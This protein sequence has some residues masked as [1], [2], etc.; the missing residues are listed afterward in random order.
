M[1][2][3]L[4]TPFDHIE[5]IVLQD[6]SSTMLDDGNYFKE[7]FTFP[8]DGNKKYN[9]GFAGFTMA[10]PSNLS[11]YS[12]VNSKFKKELNQDIGG[13]FI[14]S[15]TYTPFVDYSQVG[16]GGDPRIGVY[17][18]QFL[19]DY[20][21]GKYEDPY[22]QVDKFRHTLS[23]NLYELRNLKKD[24]E[25][26]KVAFRNAITYI[27]DEET[28][29]RKSYQ[30]YIYT[31]CEHLAE[32]FA[33]LSNIR[34]SHEI[35]GLK[36]PH[37]EWEG[38]LA[39]DIWY[40]LLYK[41]IDA[42]YPFD[43]RYM[44]LN[45]M[46]RR[47]YN[48]SGSVTMDDG[49]VL[50]LR[51]GGTC[52]WAGDTSD[53][54]GLE[55]MTD[56]ISPDYIYIWDSNLWTDYRK[57][58]K[59]IAGT[60]KECT[61]PRGVLEKVQRVVKGLEYKWKY[62]AGQLKIG[63]TNQYYNRDSDGDYEWFKQPGKVYANHSD[64]GADYP[65]YSQF[66]KYVNLHLGAAYDAMKGKEYCELVGK[67]GT[68]DASG[69]ITYV[70]PVFSDVVDKRE[71]LDDMVESGFKALV[72]AF[73]VVQNEHLF[74]VYNS[75]TKQVEEFDPAKAGQYSQSQCAIALERVFS[76]IYKYL[77][78]KSTTGET[79]QRHINID[80]G[81]KY[82]TTKSLLESD[83][84]LGI[85]FD[86]SDEKKYL[87]YLKKLNDC[88]AETNF[89][90]NPPVNPYGFTKDEYEV[91]GQ[92]CEILSKQALGW[93]DEKWDLCP[94]LQRSETRSPQFSPRKLMSRG[95]TAR[96]SD[97]S[98]SKRLYLD[99]TKKGYMDQGWV[100]QNEI[101]VPE[102]WHSTWPTPDRLCIELDET[103]DGIDLSK[104]VLRSNPTYTYSSELVSNCAVAGYTLSRNDSLIR[105]TADQVVNTVDFGDDDSLLVYAAW[106][107]EYILEFKSD[108]SHYKSEGWG[109]QWQDPEPKGS[110]APKKLPQSGGTAPQ[111][112]FYPPG[113]FT[114]DGTQY[115]ERK[116]KFK[117]YADEQDPPRWADP[118]EYNPDQQPVSLYGFKYWKCTIGGQNYS[119]R[120]GDPIRVNVFNLDSAP[121]VK[122]TA[123][124][125]RA[126]D[127]IKFNIY[128]TLYCEVCIDTTINKVVYP[129]H[130]P[131]ITNG[132]YRFYGWSSA[133]GDYLPGVDRSTTI[134]C[135]P[136]SPTDT[137]VCEGQPDY[138]VCKEDEKDYDDPIDAYLIEYV[139]KKFT[140]TFKYMGD[141]GSSKS[142][143]M[144]VLQNRKLP[145]FHIH[146]SYKS[147]ESTFTF[148]H[149]LLLEPGNLTSSMTVLSD[150]TFVAIYDETKDVSLPDEEIEQPGQGA[151]SDG[152][153]QDDV[154]ELHPSPDCKFCPIVG[155]DPRAYEDHFGE[156][157]ECPY[158]VIL[159]DLYGEANKTPKESPNDLKQTTII[160]MKDIENVL[161]ALFKVN[162]DIAHREYFLKIDVPEPSNWWY[163][164]KEVSN[165]ETKWI[166]FEPYVELKFSNL[167][168]DNQ[169]DEEGNLIC[170]VSTNS[171]GVPVDRDIKITPVNR[172]LEYNSTSN[173]CVQYNDIYYCYDFKQDWQSTQKRKGSGDGTEGVSVKTDDSQ[174]FY[175]VKP[176]CLYENTQLQ[177][178][179][180][181]NDY[182]RHRLLDTN[183]TAIQ[184]AKTQVRT[185][186]SIVKKYRPVKMPDVRDIFDD[187]HA[188]SSSKYDADVDNN[189]GV[190]GWCTIPSKTMVNMEYN[191]GALYVPSS[192]DHH[193]RVSGSNFLQMDND[194]KN[195]YRV[196]EQGNLVDNAKNTWVWLYNTR[197]WTYFA[198]PFFDVGRNNEVYSAQ[199]DEYPR[200]LW[201]E[202]S[203]H[204]NGIIFEKTS[205]GRSGD[206]TF[207][208]IAQT[209]QFLARYHHNESNLKV[210]A[211]KYTNLLDYATLRKLTRKQEFNDVYGSE[212]ANLP[213][214]F[215]FPFQDW[216]DDYNKTS[217]FVGLTL[218]EYDPKSS[219]T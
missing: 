196:Q 69:N 21:T 120:P 68:E 153:E 169:L 1:I 25:E 53:A 174:E 86:D 101:G 158:V 24:L 41:E 175:K 73:A 122:M 106:N 32:L 99:F 74:N 123:Y 45:P 141:D 11:D 38:I 212:Y 42:K 49:K 193:N 29:E 142:H 210:L 184:R 203:N 92:F 23:S 77:Q 12:I 55:W 64:A 14:D 168:S 130:A 67:D 103:L 90:T 117:Y 163:G 82:L 81:Y 118:T 145:G 75:N 138:I 214:G 4:N 119:L 199:L 183:C 192:Y 191:E 34:M 31:L 209:C 80:N 173:K 207:L 159:R 89:S 172:E 98:N 186:T 217:S 115:G 200:E 105:F 133:E 84:E 126:W 178:P 146:N 116:R 132:D 88:L 107:P 36:H 125:E 30:V 161:K 218:G 219:S 164:Y 51:S 62:Y 204:I 85:Y 160:E 35:Y 162:L 136:S 114:P 202:N 131:V 216:V 195:V 33:K 166:S 58:S 188:A 15:F 179:I 6:F 206:P 57:N 208:G 19:N 97:E 9:G 171:Q 79:F 3:V 198:K 144:S 10:D 140:V 94:I 152:V 93:L 108:D 100:A 96:A 71:L 154:P 180:D 215:R 190:F 2:E 129:E 13:F 134:I 110:M 139:P 5:R 17:S 147:G 124:W 187:C 50:N 47:K 52:R 150:L 54:P 194:F 56:E 78:F 76:R 95:L 72:D 148:R 22:C 156:L 44:N 121:V 60:R 151:M 63:N 127:V 37:C 27:A 59:S 165:D 28:K 181:G 43:E 40:N 66:T 197:D 155:Q 111:C 213:K 176:L 91:L 185:F 83:H 109:E 48:G 170:S 16:E 177:S 70:K 87:R 143:S 61:T 135:G 128:D 112:T 149:W 39:L 201:P 205:T 182:I 211:E 20:N 46:Q 102:D 26:A 167:H 104:V 65:K 18:D 137:I 7:L 189:Y 157:G 8:A 113:T